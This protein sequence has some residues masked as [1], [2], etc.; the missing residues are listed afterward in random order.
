MFSLLIT[1]SVACFGII[2]DYTLNLHFVFKLLKRTERH[3]IQKRESY[4]PCVTAV[5]S[6]LTF[7]TTLAVRLPTGFQTTF[8]RFV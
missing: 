8:Q 4:S 7:F 5:F 6:Q 1:N 2:V 3:H